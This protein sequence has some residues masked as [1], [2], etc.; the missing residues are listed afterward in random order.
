MTLANA[1]FAL[2]MRANSGDYDNT[3]IAN[4]EDATYV[5]D[6]KCKV[7]INVQASE[8][9]VITGGDSDEFII[10]SNSITLP[11]SSTTTSTVS[12]NYTAPSDDNPGTGWK[13]T[14][15]SSKALT[16]KFGSND[17]LDSITSIS[18]DNNIDQTYTFTV[19]C[20]GL[21]GLKT[22]NVG[23]G[24]TGVVGSKVTLKVANCNALIGIECA[25]GG[26]GDKNGSTGGTSNVTIDNCQSLRTV[27][28]SNGGDGNTGSGGNGNASNVTISNCAS[29]TTLNC[30]NGGSGSSSDGSN[31]T[32]TLT[33]CMISP[34]FKYATGTMS[35]PLKATFNRCFIRIP[36]RTGY[37]LE[38]D[39][40]PQSGGSI[41]TTG[42]FHI[43]NTT[44]IT[45]STHFKCRVSDKDLDKLSNRAAMNSI[46]RYLITN[47]R[48]VHS[49]T[50]NTFLDTYSFQS[51]TINGEFH[52]CSID[53]TILT[54]Q[55][56]GYYVL[57]SVMF[58]NTTTM[59]IR[60]K[61][62]K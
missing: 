16:F 26:I 58:Q 51:E 8:R 5:I 41:T 18:T 25:K 14:N 43:T 24:N 7:T 36:E 10:N 28:C 53:G 29:I 44:P 55:S 20:Y 50:I 22:I 40:D 33:N 37:A 47:V 56:G 38:F 52:L 62:Q 21:S 9:L 12:Y 35:F 23:N 15:S 4:T 45:N 3:F 2:R 27:N 30:S 1:N 34:E 54:V 13:L 49:V 46:S 32:V 11:A 59:P 6:T 61:L 42:S 57:N 48:D 17:T 19:E 39:L 31:C 60:I